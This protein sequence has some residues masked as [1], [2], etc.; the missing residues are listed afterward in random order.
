LRPIKGNNVP[1]SE[2]VEIPI[3]FGDQVLHIGFIVMDGS[4]CQI[5]LGIDVLSQLR[6]DISYPRELLIL[7][8]GEKLIELQLY[9]KQMLEKGSFEEDY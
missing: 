3:E 1:V 7:R 2:Y 8:D 4:A 5:L 9:S 6:A